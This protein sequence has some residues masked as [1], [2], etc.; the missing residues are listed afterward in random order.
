MNLV[1]HYSGHV[2]VPIISFILDFIYDYLI[3]SIHKKIFAP[4]TYVTV[5]IV[6]YLFSHLS[7]FHALVST[8]HPTEI[9]QPLASIGRYIAVFSRYIDLLYTRISVYKPILRNSFPLAKSPRARLD[10]SSLDY[11]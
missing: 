3:D 9:E 6:E 5:D 11:F 4:A 2:K 1:R 8:L 10:M 7:T